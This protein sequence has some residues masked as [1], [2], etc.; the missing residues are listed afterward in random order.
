MKY[1]AW[2]KIGFD[3]QTIA[4]D[5]KDNASAYAFA[6]SCATDLG[7]LETIRRYANYE[8]KHAVDYVVY[9]RAPE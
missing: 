2:Y 4:F 3:F 9:K 5:E 8:D 1:L 6:K 7:T